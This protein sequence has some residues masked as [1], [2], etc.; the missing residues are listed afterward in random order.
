MNSE[1][2]MTV[3]IYTVDGSLKAMMICS[4]AVSHVGDNIVIV[5]EESLQATTQA[6]SQNVMQPDVATFELGSVSNN[7]LDGVNINSSQIYIEFD[8]IMVFESTV[9]EGGIYWISVGAQYDGGDQVWIGQKSF[10]TS[11][12]N[13]TE[14]PDYTATFDFNGPSIAS[15]GSHF[16]MNLDMIIPQQMAS[17]VVKVTAPLGTSSVMSACHI[18]IVSVGR[19]YECL[20]IFDAGTEYTLDSGGEFNKEALL[21]LGTMR[22]TVAPFNNDPQDEL[23]A[24]E[25]LWIMGSSNEITVGT[26]YDVCAEVMMNGSPIS[27]LCLS[28]S[29]GIPMVPLVEPEEPDSLEL[30]TLFGDNVTVSSSLTVDLVITL[31]QNTIADYSIIFDMPF[32]GTALMSICGVWFLSTG[33]NVPCIYDMHVA[34]SSRGDPGINDR[35][36]INLSAIRNLGLRNGPD[37]DKLT[38]R[39]VLKIEDHPLNSPG[40]IV[41]PIAHV[42]SNQVRKSLTV[43]SP[44]SGPGIPYFT[45]GN[46]PNGNIY[47]N[48]AISSSVVLI[49]PPGWAYDSFTVHARLQGSPPALSI[50][51]ARLSFVGENFLCTLNDVDAINDNIE[52]TVQQGFVREATVNLGLLSNTASSSSYFYLM[53]N[54]MIIDFVVVLK[55]QSYGPTYDINVT[56]SSG[57]IVHSLVETITTGASLPN[58]PGNVDG[59]ANYLELVYP[60]TNQIAPGD[61]A[62]F[63][64]HVGVPTGYVAYFTLAVTVNDTMHICALEGFKVGKYYPC[65]NESKD[66]SPQYERSADSKTNVKATYSMSALNIGSLSYPTYDSQEDFLV[67]ELVVQL[68]AD[69]NIAYDGAEFSVNV[70]YV[71]G[72]TLEWD[73]QYHLTVAHSLLQPQLYGTAVFDIYL[74]SP[75]IIVRGGAFKAI[76][77][78][79]VPVGTSM[80]YNVSFYVDSPNLGHLSICDVRIASIGSNLK[81]VVAK[82]TFESTSEI[83]VHGTNDRVTMDIGYI[84]NVGDPLIGYDPSENTIEFAVFARVMN[85]PDLVVGSG[86][87]LNADLI[88]DDGVNGIVTNT[89]TLVLSIDSI[90]PAD[91]LDIGPLNANDTAS[92]DLQGPN[93]LTSAR[94]GDT[95]FYDVNMSLPV[96]LASLSVDV[97]LPFTDT[98]QMAVVAVNVVHWGRNIGCVDPNVQTSFISSDNSSQ[99]DQAWI[100]FGVVVNAGTTRFTDEWM[101]DDDTVTVSVEVVITDALENSHGAALWFSAGVIYANQLIWIGDQLMNVSRDNLERPYLDINVTQTSEVTGLVVGDSVSY[102]ITVYHQ[103]YSSAEALN[104]TLSVFL[105]PFIVQSGYQYQGKEPQ[106][107]TVDQSG[108][109]LKF[110]RLFFTD[111]VS[112]Q[113]D[114]L[115]DPLQTLEMNGDM[116][117]TTPI[118]LIYTMYP[119]SGNV[120][121]TGT[122]FSEPGLKVT[123]FSFNVQNGGSPACNTALG[124]ESGAIQDCQ[125]IA[126]YDPEVTAPSHN[127]RLNAVNAW[128]TQSRSDDYYRWLRIDL[129]KRHRVTGV[130]T[131]GGEGTDADGNHYEG[132]ISTFKIHFSDDDMIYSYAYSLSTSSVQFLHT[133]SPGD[134]DAI[135]HNDFL[136]PVDA[137]YILLYINSYS[138]SADETYTSLRMELYGCPLETNPAPDVC[139]VPAVDILPEEYDRSFV[140]DTNN[141]T[142]YLCDVSRDD[143]LPP[144]FMLNSLDSLVIELGRKYWEC[145]S[146]SDGLTWKSL[147]DQVRS[148]I[149]YHKANSTVY[150]LSVKNIEG[151]HFISTR[152]GGLKWNSVSALEWDDVKSDVVNFVAAVNVPYISRDSTFD[153]NDPDIDPLFTLDDWGASFGGINRFDG[154]KWGKVLDWNI[155]PSFDCV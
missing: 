50:C 56:S 57:S 29:A 141:D 40:S 42:N 32:D 62:K 65:L 88:Q 5:Q 113:I 48:S 60:S 3:E 84:C 43:V 46:R 109:T 114:A 133:Y 116:N 120:Y 61:F 123:S 96:G 14:P 83:G 25:I 110:A 74:D 81:C 107:V 15:K 139:A 28:V 125:I 134:V 142:L 115:I 102:N 85:S 19:D 33:F 34:L 1:T 79:E 16:L 92:F 37:D 80:P 6:S 136:F 121:P 153:S 68:S 149:G 132:Q 106:L 137:R 58:L 8:A 131:Q 108:I 101:E 51:E 24:I 112:V 119:R 22:K 87:I 124:M 9:I 13:Y 53:D 10:T 77:T 138:L 94:P 127:A 55:G 93:V 151:T 44:D 54:V 27:M 129:G 100:D 89:D 147:S 140:V 126:S 7:G 155:C 23:I 146:T 49:I 117:A 154:T 95:V 30:T 59:L 75:S 111:T 31:P 69:L 38:I 152:D 18:G 135:T 98:A 41:E 39:S 143:T 4:P 70:S 122:V 130:A 64:I 86:V 12:T 11:L 66:I 73:A 2:D 91:L 71:C 67:F 35:A 145:G 105:P 99:Y 76:T 128:K 20:P 144:R 90:S 103:A 97:D 118:E 45:L 36:A 63:H 104:V 52:Y 21:Q 17:I 82:S 47:P 148:V 72:G 150:A 26:S 78:I